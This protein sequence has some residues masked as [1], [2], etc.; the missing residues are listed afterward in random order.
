MKNLNFKSLTLWMSVVS[1]LMLVMGNYNWFEVI[2]ME[3]EVFYQVC[4]GILGILTTIG[5][6]KNNQK[7]GE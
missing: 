1:L 2:K 7:E 5:I 4:I 3:K 6:I